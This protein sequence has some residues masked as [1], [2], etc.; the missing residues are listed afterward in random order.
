MYIYICIH[1]FTHTYIFIYIS[2]YVSI[3]NH[4]LIARQR[5]QGK[6]SESQVMAHT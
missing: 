6:D 5:E 4:F 3:H 1:I 2:T